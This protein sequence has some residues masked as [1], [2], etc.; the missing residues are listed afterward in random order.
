M[1]FRARSPSD[2]LR[3]RC[4]EEIDYQHHAIDIVAGLKTVKDTWKSVHD[5]QSILSQQIH[6]WYLLEKVQTIDRSKGTSS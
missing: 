2:M 6:N 3:G 4:S 1:E 5:V